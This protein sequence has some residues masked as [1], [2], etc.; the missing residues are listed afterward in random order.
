MTGLNARLFIAA[1][2]GGGEAPMRRLSLHLLVHLLLHLFLHLHLYLHLHLHLFIWFGPVCG[3][4]MWQ[5]V[6]LYV[7][8]VVFGR[9]LYCVL[10]V[11]FMNSVCGW[12]VYISVYQEA[13][14]VGS[15]E[16]WGSRS[17]GPDARS[18]KFNSPLCAQT[19]F[20]IGWQFWWSVGTSWFVA[21]AI[22]RVSEH[23]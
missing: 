17:K 22:V 20:C 11:G 23:D 15:M 12:W 14:C 7:S 6:L 2:L 8:V 3:S 10:G 19:I 16:T 18:R 4:S 13:V 1:Y 5:C 9:A 21:I